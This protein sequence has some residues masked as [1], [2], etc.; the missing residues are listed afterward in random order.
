[1]S[2]VYEFSRQGKNGGFV[3]SNHGFDSGKGKI[4]LPEQKIKGRYVVESLED[5]GSFIIAKNPVKVKIVKSVRVWN[6]EDF[7]AIS[8]QLGSQ[9]SGWIGST[10]YE[11]FGGTSE[12][13]NVYEKE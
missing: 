7:F 11:F 2:S 10:F 3:A 12:G 5:K 1:M 8:N 6:T 9:Q 4:I 13:Y